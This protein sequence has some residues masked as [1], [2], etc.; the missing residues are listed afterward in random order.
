MVAGKFFIVVRYTPQHVSVYS[1]HLCIFVPNAGAV[2]SNR[3]PCRC[4]GSFSN[5][6]L[7]ESKLCSL[8]KNLA[9]V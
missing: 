1:L 6:R 9:Y 2:G 7:D 4:W 3:N 8:R 5:M